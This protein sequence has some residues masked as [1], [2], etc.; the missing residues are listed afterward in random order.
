MLALV[1]NYEGSVL[2]SDSIFTARELDPAYSFISLAAGAAVFYWM[3]FGRR[4]AA[5]SSA[6]T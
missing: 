3:F 2:A 1:A 5:M 4:S 6:G